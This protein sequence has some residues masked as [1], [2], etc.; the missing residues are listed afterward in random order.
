MTVLIAGG[1]S[2]TWG[3]ELA[4]VSDANNS[5]QFSNHSWSALLAQHLDMGYACTALPGASN[6]SIA[7]R[8]MRGCENTRSQ[9]DV[10]VAVM[11]TFANRFEFRFNQDTGERDTP[12]YSITPWTHES[13]IDRIRNSFANV[14]DAILNHHAQH[15][16][17]MTDKG[18]SD[19]SKNY[20]KHVGDSEVWEYYTTYKEIL[21]LQQY[22][23]SNNIPYVFTH[24]EPLFVEQS[25]DVDLDV[26][27]KQI[28]MSHFYHFD[29][30]YRWA[31][32]NNF[33]IGTTHPLE[34]AHA[35]FSHMLKKFTDQ[36]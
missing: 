1:D 8:V 27:R 13:N 2:F 19:F 16:K 6:G 24:V 22:L 21:F 17:H 30:F 15:N 18:I 14:N 31:C 25:T 20:Y 29:G 11:W 23:V 5:N 28:D 34:P 26:V 36:I 3:S 12:W 7:R 4:D 9:H 10:F 32:E 35:T 33:P